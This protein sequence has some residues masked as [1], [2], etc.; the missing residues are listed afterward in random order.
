ME[1]PEM[2]VLWYSEAVGWG[3]IGHRSL[4][5]WSGSSLVLEHFSN[6]RWDK[7]APAALLA[8]SYLPETCPGISQS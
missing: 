1:F 2:L 6:G 4:L 3:S 7:Q 8:S 5:L